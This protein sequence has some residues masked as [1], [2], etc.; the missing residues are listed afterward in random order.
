MK[1]I[2][3][4]IITFAVIALTAVSFTACGNQNGASNNTTQQT[5]AAADPYTGADIIG[6]W[7][8]TDEI[9]GDW[10]WTFNTN[11]TCHLEGITTG[12]QG[13]GAFTL[14]EDQPGSVHVNMKD[15]DKE[16]TYTYTIE[17]NELTLQSEYSNYHCVKQ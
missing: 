4:R 6:S 3:C 14:P 13:D 1:K 11:G 16:K 2:I 9:N 12:F 10:I 7:K 5:P 17:G 8:Q 15:W